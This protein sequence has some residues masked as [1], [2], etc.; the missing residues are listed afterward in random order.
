M[1]KNEIN[2]LTMYKGDVQ[3]TLFRFSGQVLLAYRD[4]PALIKI[5]EEL[6]RLLAQN[7]DFYKQISN[8]IPPLHLKVL[9]VLALQ[10]RNENSRLN[11]NVDED[12]SNFSFHIECDLYLTE[13]NLFGIDHTLEYVFNVLRDRRSY[14]L[15]NELSTQLENLQEAGM[16]FIIE[17][18]LLNGKKGLNAPIY[19]KSRISW[20]KNKVDKCV[21]LNEITDEQFRHVD[22]QRVPFSFSGGITSDSYMNLWKLISLVES[23]DYLSE[24]R[25]ELESTPLSESEQSAY[26]KSAKQVKEFIKNDVYGSDVDSKLQSLLSIAEELEHPLN[27]SIVRSKVYRYSEHPYLMNGDVYTLLSLIESWKEYQ[28]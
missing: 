8:D 19:L 18:W 27:N 17:G 10:Y 1:L 26:I 15:A 9:R 24:V 3:S 12:V 13:A 16:S 2:N 28:K 23:S 22:A 7:R 11:T 20:L 6:N 4:R 14:D 25:S 5:S 21:S